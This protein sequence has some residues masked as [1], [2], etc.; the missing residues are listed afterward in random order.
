MNVRRAGWLVVSRRQV[1][2]APDEDDDA[3]REE[4][5]PKGD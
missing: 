1:R 3:Q 5:D 2:E 4:H